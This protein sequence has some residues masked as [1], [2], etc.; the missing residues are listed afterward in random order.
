MIELGRDSA[1]RFGHWVAGHIVQDVPEDLA[2][3]EYDC[4]KPRCTLDEWATCERRV[5]KTAG[6]PLPDGPD[7]VR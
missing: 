7:P 2:F 6:E 4:R 3:C 1:K 5:R